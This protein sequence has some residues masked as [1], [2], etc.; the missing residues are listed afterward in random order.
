M[1]GFHRICTRLGRGPGVV[2]CCAVL[3]CACNRIPDR[4]QARSWFSG[5]RK[6]L[7]TIESD[8][9]KALALFPYA[10]P[11]FRCAP[12]GLTPPTPG[13]LPG[14]NVC[15]R[16][17]LDWL[18]QASKAEQRFYRKTRSRWLD[19]ESVIG[20]GIYIQRFSPLRLPATLAK[21]RLYHH[22]QS[23][24]HAKARAN[25]H[26][27][28]PPEKG[29][30]DGKYQVGWGL[31]QLGFQAGKHRYDGSGYRPQLDVI[32]SFHYKELVIKIEVNLLAKGSLPTR[33][34]DQMRAVCK[35][36]ENQP[37]G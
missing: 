19:H 14:G 6:T 17:H 29:F 25:K 7:E 16:A 2:L 35:L 26:G 18:K 21:R 9:R 22:W 31:G 8:L 11:G 27:S 3:L 36:A 37:R 33:W 20:V 12:G 13:V 34:R 30:A 5:H 1:R 32:W 10:D 23:G 4:K 28:I 24:C 15:D